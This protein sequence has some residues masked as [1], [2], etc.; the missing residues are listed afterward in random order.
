MT[1]IGPR[2]LALFLFAA[3][4]PPLSARPLLDPETEQLLVDAVQAAAEIDL[5]N[6]RCR[7]DVSGRL[8]DN[9]NKELVS[10]FRMTVLEVEDDLFADG[11][12]RRAKDR[13][14]QDFL[15]KLKEAGGCKEAKKAGMA[16][17]LRERYDELMRKIG[18]LP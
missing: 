6:A 1:G 4:I 12:Y 11:S 9:L 17:R 16:I 14:E 13:L 2:L 5:Y 18:R 7:S 8:T 10:K 15:T 3:S